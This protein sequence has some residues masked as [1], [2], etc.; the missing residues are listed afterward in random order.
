MNLLHQI[1]VSCFRSMRLLPF[2]SQLS[3][4]TQFLHHL[5]VRHRPDPGPVCPTCD[6]P[7]DFLEAASLGPSHEC[8]SCRDEPTRLGRALAA[9]LFEDPLREAIHAYKYRSVRSH[10]KPPSD[11]MVAQVNMTVPLDVVI[12]VPLHLTRLRSRGF[13]QHSFSL[14]ASAS[15]SVS[16]SAMITLP[17]SVPHSRR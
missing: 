13:N 2:S 8:R 16:R 1:L 12:T 9:E 3:R 4:S 14:M 15:A 11:W 10:S 17:G 6:R 7:F 5:L